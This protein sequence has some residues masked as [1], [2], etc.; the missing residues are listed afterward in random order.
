MSFVNPFSPVA[1]KILASNGRDYARCMAF[2]I[3]RLRVQFQS[4]LFG[5]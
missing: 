4:A 2:R 3:L 1:S 5:L